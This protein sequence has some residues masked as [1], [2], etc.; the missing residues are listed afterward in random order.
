M[1]EL[2]ALEFESW[3]EAAACFDHQE[4]GFFPARDDAAGI[5]RAKAVCATCLVRDDC[6]LF[7]IETNQP[8][9]IWGGMTVRERAR[10]RRRWLKDMR[11]AS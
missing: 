9:G 2:L 7:A 4:V 6:L 11:E 3:R 5:S 8:D 1:R 10:L